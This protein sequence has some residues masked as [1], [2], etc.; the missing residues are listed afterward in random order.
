MLILLLAGF[1]I[2]WSQ[3][4]ILKALALI[5]GLILIL[6]NYDKKEDL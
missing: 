2:G 3:P 5:V 1:L 4:N 6:E